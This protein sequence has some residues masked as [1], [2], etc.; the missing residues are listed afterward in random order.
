MDGMGAAQRGW[1]DLGQAVAADLAFLDE[2]GEGFRDLFDRTI[3]FA[4]MN[5]IKVDM[6][7]VQPLQ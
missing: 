2:A 3:L 7:C 4:A 6:V 1:R 5:V